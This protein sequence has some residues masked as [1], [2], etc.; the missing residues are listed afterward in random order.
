ETAGIRS[1][2]LAVP[3]QRRID[4]DARRQAGVHE[5]RFPAPPA[6]SAAAG[7]RRPHEHRAD[8]DASETAAS[9]LRLASAAR[10]RQVAGRRLPVDGGA[11]PGG[12]AIPAP[13]SAA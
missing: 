13:L 9:E 12:A 5:L 3:D 10:L 6:V 11:V 2:E 8:G 1:A 7:L 4:S